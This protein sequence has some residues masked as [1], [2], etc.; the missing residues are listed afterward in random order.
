M[1]TVPLILYIKSE[2]YLNITLG[3]LVP[4]RPQGMI[5]PQGTIQFPKWHQIDSNLIICEFSNT[6]CCTNISRHKEFIL[7]F[8]ITKILCLV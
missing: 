6:F 2:N 4:Q 3:H 7:N 5:R 8:I 1:V